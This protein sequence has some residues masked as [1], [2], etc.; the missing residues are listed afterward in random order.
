MKNISKGRTGATLAPL[1]DGGMLS[2]I[3]RY[4][5]NP[6]TFRTIGGVLMVNATQ[7]A[8]PFGKRPSLWLRLPVARK[9]IR[10][11]QREKK[12]PIVIT[13]G[14]RDNGGT[15]IHED[16][17]IEFARWLSPAY[18]VWCNDRIK[19]LLCQGVTLQH[20]QEQP[21]VNSLDDALMTL[22]ESAELVTALKAERAERERLEA[23]LSS[24]KRLIDGL[25]SKSE[26]YK[27]TQIQ[28]FKT[29]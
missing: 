17:A 20:P 2:Q 19:E 8:K 5:D 26:T 29:R 28:L 14:G 25:P 27:D 6:I 3:L 10:I 7:M 15:Y 16:L 23:V 1:S 21:R 22:R 4:N 13:K 11:I 12:H 18:A 9:F 24:V